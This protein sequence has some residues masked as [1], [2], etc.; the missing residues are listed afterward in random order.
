MLNQHARIGWNR[1]KKCPFDRSMYMIHEEKPRWV[2]FFRSD[3]IAL[4]KGL[5]NWMVWTPLVF[6]K[7]LMGWDSVTVVRNLCLHTHFRS[8]AQTVLQCPRAK[9]MTGQSSYRRKA[10]HV[11]SGMTKKLSLSIFLTTHPEVSCSLLLNCWFGRFLISILLWHP[12]Y[13]TLNKW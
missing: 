8:G 10:A 13:S 9:F 1:C 7:D 3:C 6:N 4:K 11:Y 5:W 2:V 12:P